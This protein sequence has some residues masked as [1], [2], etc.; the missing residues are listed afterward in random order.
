[1]QKYQCMAC[2]WIYDPAENDN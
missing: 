1:M 2:G